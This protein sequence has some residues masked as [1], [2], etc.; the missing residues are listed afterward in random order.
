MDVAPGVKTVGE[1]EVLAFLENEVASGEGILID[2][3]TPKWFVDGTIPGSVNIPY[4][5]FE[6]DLE[7]EL[8]GTL[9][10]IGVTINDDGSYDFSTAK[11]LLLFCNG[12]WCGQSPRAI[13]NLLELGYPAEK[14]FYYRGG[15]QLW[16]L[17]GLTVLVP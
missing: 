11:D 4:T 6:S 8:E 15:M 16:R 1:L 13:R 17:L 2:A 10:D 3:R 14:L 9:E 12:P 7:I 5:D